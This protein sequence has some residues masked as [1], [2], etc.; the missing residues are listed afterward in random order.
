MFAIPYHF[1]FNILNW[2]TYVKPKKYYDICIYNVRHLTKFTEEIVGNL[3]PDY[4]SGFPDD[5]N[6]FHWK[7]DRYVIV[8]DNYLLLKIRTIKAS[9]MKNYK[10]KVLSKKFG[11]KGK[12]FDSVMMLLFDRMLLNKK[13]L[14]YE[15]EN[16]SDF[17]EYA[18]LYYKALMLGEFDDGIL[19][20]L[21]NTE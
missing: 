4:I 1:G 19:Q 21:S 18:D 13:L 17:I 16:D 8:N 9:S 14:Y 11:T 3:Y 20:E 5:N 7:N 6:L 10:L 15:L 12:F 2:G